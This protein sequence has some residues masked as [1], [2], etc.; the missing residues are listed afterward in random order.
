MQIRVGIGV[1]VAAASLCAG[2][3]NVQG[4]PQSPHPTVTPT[5]DTPADIAARKAIAV[6]RGYAAH[7]DPGDT[8]WPHKVIMRDQALGDL[9]VEE[10]NLDG[11]RQAYSDQLAD[12]H[13]FAAAAPQYIARELDVS[14]ADEKL[15]DV[16]LAQGDVSGAL[17]VYQEDLALSRRHLAVADTTPSIDRRKT[18]RVTQL[19]VAISLQKVGDALAA[20]GDVAGARGDYSEALSFVRPLAESNPR[21]PDVQRD[22]AVCLWHL[23]ELGGASVQWSDVVAHLEAMQAKHI[24]APGFDY[25]LPS[26]NRRASLQVTP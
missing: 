3:A 13:R 15:G 7:R 1:L 5:Q 19:Y 11:A 2:P 24:I 22:L 26:A 12:A 6:A 14:A 16:M 25:C 17:S 18:K 23:A 8:E 10:G 4:A 9:L 21:D 20:K